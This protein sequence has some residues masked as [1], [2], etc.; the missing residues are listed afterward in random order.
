MIKYSIQYKVIEGNGEIKWR[1]VETE[2]F[3]THEVAYAEAKKHISARKKQIKELPKSITQGWVQ[4]IDY[5]IIEVTVEDKIV[6]QGNVSDNGCYYED[7]RLLV[8]EES[9]DGI[10]GRNFMGENVR[11]TIERII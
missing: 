3:N 6:V 2:L 1:D 9:I 11:V 4:S 8:N 7:Y 5:K 10:I